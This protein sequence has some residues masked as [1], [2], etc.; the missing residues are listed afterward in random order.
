M[1]NGEKNGR[2][3]ELELSGSLTSDYYKA[4]V[5]KAIWYWHKNRNIDQ[6][7]RTE[8]PKIN[9]HTYSQLIYNKG[10]KTIQWRRESLFNKW[11]YKHWTDICKR[12]TLKH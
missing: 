10:G 12:M 9:P 6:W 7:S 11:C 3:T 8:S 4:T 1:V 5:I 2:K